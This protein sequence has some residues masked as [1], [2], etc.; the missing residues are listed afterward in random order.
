MHS[1]TIK[2]SKWI[3]ISAT[4]KISGII[5]SNRTA[6][7]TQIPDNIQNP[8]ISAYCVQYSMSLR[9]SVTV[10]LKRP[11]GRT[12]ENVSV[13]C[14]T[15]KLQMN[16]PGGRILRFVLEIFKKGTTIDWLKYSHKSVGGIWSTSEKWNTIKHQTA[17]QFI[18]FLR[19]LSAKRIQ[20]KKMN[21]PTPEEHTRQTVQEDR[22]ATNVKKHILANRVEQDPNPM[23]QEMK[24]L[25]RLH[26][27]ALRNY[28]R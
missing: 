26:R 8:E 3:R 28:I 7:S 20:I 9:K 6:T 13:V 19:P 5:H 14:R 23:W 21:H 4:P 17:S 15:S 24:R 2:R 18:G 11:H 10:R 16:T 27:T 1:D 22:D 25:I 12:Q